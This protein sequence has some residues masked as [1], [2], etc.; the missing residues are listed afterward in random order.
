[1]NIK[2]ISSKLEDY[3]E[4]IY[5][6]QQRSIVARVKDLAQMLGVRPPT[7]ISA[8]QRL[9]DLELV[10]HQHYGYIRLTEEGLA[11]AKSIYKRHETLLAFLVDILNID[12]EKALPQACGMEHSISLSTRDKFELLTDFIKSDP[13][14]WKKWQEFREGNK[15]EK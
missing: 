4:A 9:T 3:L 11:I 14:I 1:M 2:K 8:V 15:D 6:L 7:A 10:E 13:A 5:L 12:V